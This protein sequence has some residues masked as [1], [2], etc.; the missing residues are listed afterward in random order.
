MNIITPRWFALPCALLL[1]TLSAQAAIVYSYQESFES[2]FG[3]WTPDHY[4]SCEPSCRFLWSITRSQD[5][6][7]DGRTSLKG[8]LNGSH[9]DGTIWVERPFTLSQLRPG[10]YKVTVSFSLWSSAKAD[11]NT[12]PVVAYIGANNPEREADFPIIGRTQAA[13]G[14][15]RYSL[16]RSVTVSP[17]TP[18]WIAFGFGATW[19][20]SRTHFLDAVSVTV[21]D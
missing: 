8:F 7:S 2:S 3:G 21:S 9:D 6:A 19:E 14:W 5:R 13:A 16:T 10:T 12:W 4:I 1:G 18:L 20:T 11:V 17:T 15:T